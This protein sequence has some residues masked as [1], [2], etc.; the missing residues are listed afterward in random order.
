VTPVVWAGDRWCALCYSKLNGKPYHKGEEINIYP[1][2]KVS[3]QQPTNTSEDIEEPT[4]QEIQ[5]TPVFIKDNSLGSPHC[6]RSIKSRTN[7]MEKPILGQCCI[8]QRT[9]ATQ[10]A[11]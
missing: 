1:Y 4:N 3:E 2:I 10:Q 5:N 6:T 9:I 11:K 8:N 7:S